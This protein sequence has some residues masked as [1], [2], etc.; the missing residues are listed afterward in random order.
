MWSTR[1]SAAVS[2]ITALIWPLRSIKLD[3]GPVLE[4]W[5]LCLIVLVPVLTA[6]RNGA[7]L[8]L[9]ILTFA[10][11]SAGYAWTIAVPIT[12]G[13]CLGAV[14]GLLW[15]LFFRLLPLR[16]STAFPVIVGSVW[17]CIQYL[18]VEIA[19]TMPA[20]SSPLYVVPFLIQPLSLVG[21][22]GLEF[23]LGSFNAC[24]AQLLFTPSKQRRRRI[25]KGLILGTTLWVGTSVLQYST[26][27]SST[28]PT[29]PVAAIS[30]GGLLPTA[31]LFC[32]N[33]TRPHFGEALPCTASLDEQMEATRR[34]F[35]ESGAKIVVW[36]EAWV[37]AYE[38]LDELEQAVAETFAPLARE[39]HILFTVGMH[40][41]DRANLAV[42]ISP[43]GEVLGY[44]GKMHPVKL[45][46]E[47]ST[48]TYGYTDLEVEG[49]WLGL[50]NLTV[51]V[52]PL[53]CYDM[54]FPESAASL[55]RRGVELILSPS[56]DWSAMR[57]HIAAYVFR[58]IE[59]RV[60]I[61]K[62]DTGWDSAIVD[63][64][65]DIT[66]S[67]MSPVSQRHAVAGTVHL[68]SSEPTMASLYG[69]V[70]PL[71]FLLFLNT[72]FWKRLNGLGIYVKLS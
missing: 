37:G 7:P 47:K 67:Y 17:A 60:P 69:R 53:I 25:F 52:A 66:A 68:G 36:S 11:A 40:T 70:V 21:F 6:Q 22:Y 9:I 24:V 57:N 1:R 71:I 15:S 32:R 50:S 42:T 45:L 61:V 58:A 5:P 64:R 35:S 33:G 3:S 43:E 14:V 38:S 10:L 31:V 16:D 28:S 13:M 41:L 27:G 48:V 44:Y 65:G 55:K 19:G 59:N 29:A 23:A 2:L 20:L 4:L 54:D 56:S 46:G 72:V 30:P 49:G 51:K 34:A 12:V 8:W 39:L 26:L 18:I 62:A 63:A